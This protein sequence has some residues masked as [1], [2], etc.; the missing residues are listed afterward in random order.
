MDVELETNVLYIYLYSDCYI[1]D[2]HTQIH[3]QAHQ[4]AWCVCCT[5]RTLLVATRRTSTPHTHTHT[6]RLADGSCQIHRQIALMRG[7][8]GNEHSSM[9]DVLR[10]FSC[11]TNNSQ[12]VL[13]TLMTDGRMDGQT[14]NRS[15]A[16]AGQQR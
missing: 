3:T 11:T 13:S 14:A 1:V 6:Q 15:R 16:G 12:L 8:K 7:H 5:V 2:T 9:D 4:H 10:V